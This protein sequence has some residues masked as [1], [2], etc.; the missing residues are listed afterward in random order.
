M[1]N[2]KRTIAPLGHEDVIDLI[3]SAASGRSASH[4]FLFQGPEHIG[5]ST[6]A[7]LLAMSVNCLSLKNGL[8]CGECE[9]C[10]K[11]AAGNFQFVTRLK[12]KFGEIPIDD[13]RSKIIAPGSL[14]VPEGFRQVYIINDVRYFNQES[15]NCFLKTLEEPTPNVLFVLV[16]SAPGSILPTIRSRCQIV[17]FS[18]IEK[19]KTQK[20]ISGMW[21][22]IGERESGFIVNASSSIGAAISAAEEETS[23]TGPRIASVMAALERILKAPV[24]EEILALWNMAY[25]VSGAEDRLAEENNLHLNEAFDKIEAA[26]LS[27]QYI[28]TAGA[29]ALLLLAK[30][31][32]RRYVQVMAYE[33]A[34]KIDSYFAACQQELE[35]FI[36]PLHQKQ[37]ERVSAKIFN[38][39]M[40]AIKKESA[41]TRRDE[42]VKMVAGLYVAFEKIF[43]LKNSAPEK[44]GNGIIERMALEASTLYSLGEIEH[45]VKKIGRGY[46]RD[47]AANINPEAYLENYFLNIIRK[48]RWM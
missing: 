39:M 30:K 46:Y 28:K 40:D 17:K 14:K 16:T 7:D 35:K 2:I 37:Q 1:I 34:G 29:Y 26:I 44:C 43:I 5:K 36:E 45:I 31:S 15:A 8:A 33:L 19:E 3:R 12:Y 48:K 32:Q 21:P 20:Y 22:D 38:E 9:R 23:G 4:S 27:R 41:R 42:Y 25:G 24:P 6:C 10:K 13:I 47:M 18:D 11:I